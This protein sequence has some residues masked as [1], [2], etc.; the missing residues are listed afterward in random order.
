V[1]ASSDA[2]DIGRLLGWA[3]RPRETPGRHDDY[4]RIVM[5]YRNEPDFAAAVDAVFTG[6]GLFLIVDERDGIIVTA[7]P[8]SPLRVTV[9][10]IMKRAQP[11]HRA[12]IGAVVLAVARTAYP[13]APMLDDPDRVAVFTTQSVVD[14]LDRAAQIHADSTSEDGGLDEERVESWRRWL[15]LAPARPNARRRSTN[16]RPGLVNRVCR[17]LADAGYLTARGDTDGGTWMA[18]PRFRHAVATLCEDSDLYPLVNGLADVA[19]ED[20]DATGAALADDV[21]D[22]DSAVYGAAP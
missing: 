1:S 17:F 11:Y 3:A 5:R 4:H 22:V 13:D 15:A 16:D 18:R 21:D 19:L 9:T 10:D 6:A 7:N 2:I 12:V 14:T 20:H 8:D